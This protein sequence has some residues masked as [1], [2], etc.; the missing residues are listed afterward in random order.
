MTAIHRDFRVEAGADFA[1]THTCLDG[2]GGP[3]DLSGFTAAMR[4]GCGYALGVE[5]TLTEAAGLTLGG[6]AGTIV[7]ALTEAQ[8]QAL[9]NSTWAIWNAIEAND[10]TLLKDADMERELRY[11]L[12]IRS[13]AGVSSRVLQGRIAIERQV[14]QGI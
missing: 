13:A 3:V 8:T 1:Y 14:G 7:I 12:T 11:D 4:I 2:A 5:L 6:G 10:P 9:Q